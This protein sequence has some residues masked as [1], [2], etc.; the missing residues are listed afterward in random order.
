M[1]NPCEA[2]ET[3]IAA[4]IADTGQGKA[5]GSEG[6]DRNRTP[7]C[8]LNHTKA[9][10][11]DR[12]HIGV[13][14]A[15]DG[16]SFFANSRIFGEFLRLQT[17]SINK[18]FR[19]HGF[20]ILANGRPEDPELANIPEYRHWKRRYNLGMTMATTE[21]EANQMETKVNRQIITRIQRPVSI[22][23]CTPDDIYQ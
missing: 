15:R 6:D 13:V 9:H 12:A 18:N 2:L 11:A 3:L 19:E 22:P 5:W 1:S 4:P 20:E 7:F 10:P 8:S 14:W 23:T 16:K 17:N 21:K